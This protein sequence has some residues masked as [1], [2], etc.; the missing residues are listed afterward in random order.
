MARFRIDG[1]IMGCLDSI[2]VLSQ[3]IDYIN[4]GFL[5][6]FVLLYA[7]IQETQR[8]LLCENIHDESLNRHVYRIPV[9]VI[10]NILH[11][12]WVDI[13]EYKKGDV[14][15]LCIESY[16]NISLKPLISI[17][18]V[19]ELCTA[20]EEMFDYFKMIIHARKV[21]TKEIED[22]S[23]KYFNDNSDFK[24]ALNLV[25]FSTCKETNIKGV[26]FFR[27]KCY[28]QDNFFQSYFKTLQ[29]YN[30]TIST[31]CLKNLVNITTGTNFYLAERN[32]A[33][34]VCVTSNG[35]YSFRKVRSIKPDDAESIQYTDSVYFDLK[36]YKTLLD[37]LRDVKEF[38]FIPKEKLLIAKTLVANYR[39]ELSVEDNNLSEI[40]I[41]YS[42]LKTL[43]GIPGL[44]ETIQ[45][46]TMNCMFDINVDSEHTI[47]TVLLVGGDDVA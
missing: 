30:F 10:V 26:S 18:I 33:F 7:N 38:H 21:Y 36:R 19:K 44:S 11:D 14:I 47:H 32:N 22:S 20:S 12:G 9:E 45:Y 25:R 40:N 27:N 34:V 15:E 35:I 31:G 8:M 24:T 4:F 3:K 16:S 41:P 29:E 1:P 2:R 39:I 6:G 23:Y 17:S 37:S 46:N 42:Y 28:I 13:T 43:I 5:D